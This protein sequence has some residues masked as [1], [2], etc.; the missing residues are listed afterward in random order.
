MKFKKIVNE[1]EIASEAM[2]KRKSRAHSKDAEKW[3]FDIPGAKFIYHG[4]W[5]DPEVDYKGVSLNYYDIEMGL[6]DIYR[7]EHPEDK[8][9]KGF[10]K[11]MADN[12]EEIRSE[13]ELLYD[14]EMEYKANNPEERYDEETYTGRVDRVKDKIRD[15]V[16]DKDADDVFDYWYSI[17]SRFGLSWRHDGFYGDY[18]KHL[19]RLADILGPEGRDIIADV[20][21]KFDQQEK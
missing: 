5:N 2:K 8:N 20:Q 11:W 3:W 12:R 6:L 14:A 18:Q 10:D 9:D 4:D 1:G 19:D 17:Q 13:L 16:G 15:I 7:D 21:R